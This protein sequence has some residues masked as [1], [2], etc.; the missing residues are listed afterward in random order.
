MVYGPIPWMFTGTKTSYSRGFKY[1]KQ[2]G[3]GTTRLDF[4]GT[5]E[6][7]TLWRLEWELVYEPKLLVQ[8][9]LTERSW[10]GS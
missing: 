10:F 9:V 3:F 7:C 8:S 1:L 6:G 5:L 2:L 4:G